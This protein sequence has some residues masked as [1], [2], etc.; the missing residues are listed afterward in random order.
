MPEEPARALTEALGLMPVSMEELLALT[1]EEAEAL[2]EQLRV[3]TGAR[4]ISVSEAPVQ[5]RVFIYDQGYRGAHA[6]AGS[7]KIHYKRSMYPVNEKGCNL[8]TVTEFASAH[9]YFEDQFGFDAR[10]IDSDVIDYG[11]AEDG[12]VEI[13]PGKPGTANLTFFSKG[14]AAGWNW[15]ARRSFA[16]NS[17]PPTRRRRL[18]GRPPTRRRASSPMYS[19]RKTQ[20][21]RA[22]R[23]G[24]GEDECQR[25][26]SVGGDDH[27]GHCRGMQADLELFK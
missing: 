9:P 18:A 24:H 2:Y 20:G 8:Y 10:I 26:A 4:E 22:E 12:R 1:R 16:C 25:H 6:V 17:S 5:E 3:Q 19:I 14:M 11:F 7:L 23:D 21:H 15:A 27:A 13:R